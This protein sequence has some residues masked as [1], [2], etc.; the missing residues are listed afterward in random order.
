MRRYIYIVILM[1]SQIAIGQQDSQYTQYMYN[2]QTVNPGYAGSRGVFSLIGL[3]RTQWVGINGA[4]KT[5][6]FSFNTPVSERVGIGVS[7]YKDQIGIS[8]E[9]YVAGDFSYAIPLNYSGTHLSFGLKGG[10]SILD[11]D[12]SRLNPNNPNDPSFSAANNIRGQ[13]SP[14]IGVGLYLRHNDLWYL[15][16]SAP[17]LLN[18]TH[19]DDIAV[20]TAN[21]RI[22]L[23]LIGG[24]VFD[25]STTWKLKPAFL[26]KGVEG[27][28][29]AIDLSANF[30]FNEK[31]TLGAAYRW[32]SAA[33]GLIGFQVTNGMMLGYAYDYDL[34]DIGNY[35]KGSHEFFL[36]FEI[37]G[38]HRLGVINPRFF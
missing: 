34:T 26:L 38:R 28:P 35:S 1:L 4:P 22:H 5:L 16:L 3:H 24:Y 36:R 21:E 9:N 37:S 31:L 11:V 13:I 20:S 27:A 2:T 8:D 10:L 33:S 30:W 6:N 32:D 17:S 12:F 19:Y 15:G 14:V 29:L 7:F 18:T 25:L 23:Y